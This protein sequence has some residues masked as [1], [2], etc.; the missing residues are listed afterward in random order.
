[1]RALVNSDWNIL[2]KF[3]TTMT[4]TNE[5]GLILRKVFSAVKPLGNCRVIMSS[6]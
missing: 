1:M 3:N 6:Y 2:F 5:S 4:K